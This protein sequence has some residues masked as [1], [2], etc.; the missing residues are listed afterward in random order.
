M[1]AIESKYTVGATNLY[2]TATVSTFARALEL[3]VENERK[4]FVKQEKKRARDIAHCKSY[5]L[6]E[7]FSRR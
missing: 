1:S 6:V 3:F 2:N 7:N 4:P 5:T